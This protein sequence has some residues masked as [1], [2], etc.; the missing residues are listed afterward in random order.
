MTSM[1]IAARPL[2][3]LRWQWSPRSSR[4]RTAPSADAT[5][6]SANATQW[7]ARGLAGAGLALIPWLVVLARN[8]PSSAHAWNWST[9]WVG[10]DMLEMFG[11]LATGLLM[12]RRDVR[13]RLTA[14]ATSA[15]LLVDAWFDIVTSGPGAHQ[16]AAVVMAA[17]LELPMAALCAILAGRRSRRSPPAIPEM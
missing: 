13:Y 9:A 1:G 6:R 10:L 11:L 8:L 16:L 17:V 7:L 3:D 4:A 14:A 15:L 12:L 5:K 2:P